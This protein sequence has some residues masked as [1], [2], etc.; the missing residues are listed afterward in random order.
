MGGDASGMVAAVGLED[1]LRKGAAMTE[2]AD[3][4]GKASTHRNADTTTH[5]GSR[6]VVIAT[7][8]TND[9]LWRPESRCIRKT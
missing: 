4:V 2:P 5:L 9:G 1:P 6:Q 3:A 8:A 7:A